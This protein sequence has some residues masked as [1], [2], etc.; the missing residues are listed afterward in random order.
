M[1]LNGID[2]RQNP[3]VRIS[4]PAGVKTYWKP[5]QAIAAHARVTITPAPNVSLNPVATAFAA[6]INMRAAGMRQMTANVA[7]AW[8]SSEIT[9]PNE[10]VAPRFELMKITTKAMVDSNS[11]KP[12][13]ATEIGACDRLYC[14]TASEIYVI[15]PSTT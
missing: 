1:S 10:R 2:R 9:L 7:D 3:S 12:M 11:T 6:N 15:R 5:L 4:I 13:P 14:S 8:V